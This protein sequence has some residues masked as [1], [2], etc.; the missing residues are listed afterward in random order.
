[1]PQRFKRPLEK[2]K[3]FIVHFSLVQVEKVFGL[4]YA[5]I[6]PTSLWSAHVF[7][8]ILRFMC[9]NIHGC[10]FSELLLTGSSLTLSLSPLH[11]ELPVWIHVTAIRVRVLSHSCSTDS[12]LLALLLWW[13][14]SSVHN[15][16]KVLSLCLQLSLQGHFA[17]E[18]PHL[19]QDLVLTFVHLR[20][21]PPYRTV[22]VLEGC[23]CSAQR[24]RAQH[25]VLCR[26]VVGWNNV[27]CLSQL[28]C[29]T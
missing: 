7:R 28:L 23:E 16:A 15:Q 22:K 18:R 29:S 14:T 9:V 19:L 13:K 12:Q 6:G 20:A 21:Q 11:T 17:F 10:V 3:L 5:I 2:V 26:L 27:K 8:L 25:V 24:M 1:M 4:L